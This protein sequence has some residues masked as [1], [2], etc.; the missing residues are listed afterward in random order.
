MERPGKGRRVWLPLRYIATANHN[1]E[2]LV[3]AHAVKVPLHAG[4]IPGG[5]EAQEAPGGL[6]GR[7]DVVSPWLALWLL[8]GI[9]RQ[10]EMVRLRPP[11]SGDP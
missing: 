9:V 11:V 5:D 2:T 8:L 7:E 1:L 6:D 3:P 4:S 10:P